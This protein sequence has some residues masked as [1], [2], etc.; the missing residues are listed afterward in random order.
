M[1]EEP[2][3][4]P[5]GKPFE[6]GTGRHP[7]DFH[8]VPEFLSSCGAGLDRLQPLASPWKCL[9]SPLDPDPVFHQPGLDPKANLHQDVAKRTSP[10]ACPSG[11]P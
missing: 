8:L 3:V 6:R 11:P 10:C 2:R 9:A 4:S 7:E 1:D 5:P